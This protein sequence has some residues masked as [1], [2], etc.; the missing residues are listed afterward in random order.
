MSTKNEVFM[1]LSVLARCYPNFELEK[2]TLDAYT[3]MLQDIPAELL[4]V[5]TVEYA[6]HGRLL[7]SVA[8]FGKR[9]TKLACRRRVS[10]R[11]TKPGMSCSTIRAAE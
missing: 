2:E 8:E 4:R 5:A 10:P 7:P 9:S 6:T 3:V 1:I 11:P